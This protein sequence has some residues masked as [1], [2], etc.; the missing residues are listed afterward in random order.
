MIAN[1]YK[2]LARVNDKATLSASRLLRQE[3]SSVWGVAIVALVSVL[4]GVAGTLGGPLV[5]QRF[6]DQATGGTTVDALVMTTIVYLG[7]S[8]AGSAGRITS[9]YFAAQVG[10]GVADR[11]RSRLFQRL[12]VDQPV[13]AVESCPVGAILEQVEGNSDIIGTTIAQAGFQLVGNL[14]AAVG[15]LAIMTVVIPPAGIGIAVL[16]V[17]MFWAFARLTREALSKWEAARQRQTEIFGFVGDA[18]AARDDLLPLG[19]SEWPT[20][21]TRSLLGS[22]FPV[23]RGAYLAGRAAWPLA[24][25][26][27]ALSFALALGFGLRGLGQGGITPGTL[28]LLY[29][30]VVLLQEPLEQVSSQ[31]DQV[32]QMM[33]VLGMSAKTIGTG[34][35]APVTPDRL[36]REPA[37]PLSVTFTDVVFGYGETPV[38][39]DVSFHVPAGRSLGIVGPTGAGKSTVINLLCGLCAPSRGRVMI[40]D[41]DAGAIPPSELAAHVTVLSQQAHLFGASLRDNI[42]LF[43]DS[44]PADRLWEVLE[45]LGAAA[46]VRALPEGLDTRVGARGRQLS[47]GEAQLIAGARA[48]TR[49][50]GLLVIDEGTSRLDPETERAWTA[51]VDRLRRDR[52]VIMVAHRL[53]T[54]SGFDEVLVMRDGRVADLVPGGQALALDVRAEVA[55]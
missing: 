20:R 52:T 25:V 8:V 19:A 46:W 55:Q 34:P 43:D 11:L 12:A 28:M 44:V 2:E 50:A 45:Q 15:A 7:V 33:A 42:T 38:L 24:Q 48:L 17:V 23:E 41:R 53:A 47:V 16:I 27:F 18:L 37:G 54:L 32:Q 3:L 29:L 51:V 13:L 26:F 39:H 9:G 22:L 6:V 5:I 21:R 31:V 30:Y 40:G 10:W 49:S 35:D 36:A 14:V 1:A 4:V